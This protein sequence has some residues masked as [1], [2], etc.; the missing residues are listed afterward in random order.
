[1]ADLFAGL[2][3]APAVTG[4]ENFLTKILCILVAAGE[5]HGVGPFPSTAG[6]ASDPWPVYAGPREFEAGGETT[7]LGV[8][9]HIAEDRFCHQVPSTA[10]GIIRFLR[11][12]CFVLNISHIVPILY[13]IRTTAEKLLWSRKARYV[14]GQMEKGD[15]ACECAMGPFTLRACLRRYLPQ[16]AGGTFHR[17]Q[18]GTGAHAGVRVRRGGVGAQASRRPLCKPCTACTPARSL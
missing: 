10:L 12:A 18:P 1:M 4:V 8:S 7:P 14:Q 17:G 16:H 9:R 15:I 5:D 13:V 6:D 11:V 3:V 2:G